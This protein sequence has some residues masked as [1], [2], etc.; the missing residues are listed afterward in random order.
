M[1]KIIAIILLMILIAAPALGHTAKTSEGIRSDNTMLYTGMTYGL[2]EVP[3]YYAG[4]STSCSSNDFQGYFEEDTCRGTDDGTTFILENDERTYIQANLIDCKTES[5]E[6]GTITIGPFGKA[7]A[8]CTAGKECKWVWTLWEPCG[9]RYQPITGAV[10]YE[11]T[12]AAEKRCIGD[13]LFSIN[14]CGEHE[15]STFCAYGCEGGA[16]RSKPLNKFDSIQNICGDGICAP[17]NDCESDCI[18]GDNETILT[19]E[20]PTGIIILLLGL[21][22]ISAV[23]LFT[24]KRRR[25]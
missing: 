5:R 24:N 1:K 18:M 10:I 17:P 12:P 14:S 13:K 2:S 25:E 21:I 19:S 16:C 3:D 7:S 15:Y 9:L 4:A 11:C 8:K 23:I 6:A 22:S 20:F